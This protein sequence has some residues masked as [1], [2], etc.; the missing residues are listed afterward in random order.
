[1]LHSLSLRSKLFSLACLAIAALIVTVTT[2]SLGIHSGVVG[3]QEIGRNRLPAVLAIQELKEVQVG[4]MS[5]TYQIALWENDTDAADQFAQIAKD[6]QQLWQRAANVWKSYEAIPKS[7]D[8]AQLWQGFST[9]WTSFKKD[10]EA[11]IA[12]VQSLA[13]NKEPSR[14]KSIFQQYLGLGGKERGSYVSTEK[15]LNAVLEVNA[16][17]VST[18]TDEAERATQL[19]KQLM[20]WIGGVAIILVALLG[21][22]ITTS[23]L[24]QMGGD[25]RDAVAITR[26]IAEGD[27]SAPIHCKEG[28]NESLLASIAYMQQ[29]L[30]NL[31]GEVRRSAENLFQS[32]G[33]LE[34][35]VRQVSAN[36]KDEESAARATAEA[37]EAIASRITLVGDSA[38][39][40]QALSAQAGSYAQEGN[41]VIAHVTQEMTLIAQAVGES[42]TLIQSLGNLSN[43]ISNIVNVIKDIADQTNLL[44][45]NA[46]IEAA[47]AGEQGRGFAVVADEVRK[48]AERTTASTGEIT[49]M[50]NNVRNGVGQAVNSMEKA[51]TW[52]QEGVG[53]V[54]NAATSMSSIH[55]GADQASTAV[56][57]I[58]SAL[59]AGNRDLL[60][61]EKRMEEIVRMVESNGQSVQ[62]M[63][64][65]TDS[66][67]NMAQ[68]LA[69]SIRRFKI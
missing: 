31:I 27:L 47:R 6:K 8:E 60:A 20:I 55:T 22:T 9:Q 68:R 67:S 4:L 12:F 36:G 64:R 49:Q 18:E 62:T 17:R 30:H 24:R 23:I 28:D 53:L 43:E 2:G 45:L 59:H 7:D 35:D 25:P 40:A 37:V 29:H 41:A 3:V 34:R 32:A 66:I 15:A 65:S 38:N 11:V 69:D 46:A 61:I 14:Q 44:A 21:L 42:S 5:L 58:T 10:D 33:S 63:A 39:T 50:I 48:L 16:H 51:S 57:E 56:T 52:V 19:S 1:M 26:R 54:Q 13:A